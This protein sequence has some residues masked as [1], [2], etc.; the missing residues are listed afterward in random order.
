V[1]Q[2]YLKIAIKGFVFGV[3]IAELGKGGKRAFGRDEKVEKLKWRRFSTVDKLHNV[4]K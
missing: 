4:I 2:T 1:L 3:D